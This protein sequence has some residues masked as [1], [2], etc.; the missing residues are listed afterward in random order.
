M[1]QG[2]NQAITGVIADNGKIGTVIKAGTVITCNNI[3]FLAK[4][5]H[6]LSGGFKHDGTGP[7][8]FNLN[9]I[10]VEVIK[11]NTV[12]RFPDFGEANLVYYA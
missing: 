3:A 4:G 8:S 1:V 11:E 9:N 10:S 12:E 5:I 2:Q 6:L 7:F